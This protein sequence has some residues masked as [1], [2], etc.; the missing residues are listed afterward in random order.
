MTR[1][2]DYYYWNEKIRM[3][4]MMSPPHPYDRLS[5]LTCKYTQGSADSSNVIEALLM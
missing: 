2:H 4:L 5:L 1:A 3:L